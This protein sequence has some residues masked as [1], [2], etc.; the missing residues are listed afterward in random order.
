MLTNKDEPKI[1]MQLT[2]ENVSIIQASKISS[3]VDLGLDRL[4]KSTKFSSQGKGRICLTF[5]GKSKELTCLT[6]EGQ[7]HTKFTRENM[8]LAF[9]N[10]RRC[11]RLFCQ[12]ASHLSG[13]L[14]L[15][16]QSLQ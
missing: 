7:S 15:P 14:P 6:L 5:K 4:K 9:K 13:Y 11:R 3:K 10:E 8:W 1:C 2:I 12:S 16:L